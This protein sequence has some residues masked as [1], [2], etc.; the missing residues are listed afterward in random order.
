NLGHLP[1]VKAAFQP[2]AAGVL[3]RAIVA[4]NIEGRKVFS[5]YALIPL[6]D[7]AVFLERPAADVYGPI[8]ASLLRTSVLLLIGLGVALLASVL[9][10]RGVARPPHGP[11][12]G[13]VCIGGG[14]LGTR[15]DIRTGDEIEILADEFNKMTAHLEE[16]HADLERKVAE[17]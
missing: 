7:W 11:R 10:A 13:G 8:Y 12:G 6:L 2:R 14:D 17:R 1:Q 15:L 9:V 5:S 3:P 16:A 4:Y